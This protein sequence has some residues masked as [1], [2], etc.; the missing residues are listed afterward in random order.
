MA[1]CAQ[2]YQYGRSNKKKIQCKHKVTIVRVRLPFLPWKIKL[3]LIIVSVC[4]LILVMWWANGSF[5]LCIMFCVPFIAVPCPSTLPHESYNIRQK[6][7]VFS[8]SLQLSSKTFLILR[9]SQQ[10]RTSH[11]HWS[12]CKVTFRLS[13]FNKLEFPYRISVNLDI[14]NFL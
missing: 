9:E 8:L 14:P 4:I 12:S 1:K 7:V 3:V 11:L 6:G 5:L 2:S 10:D 13:L